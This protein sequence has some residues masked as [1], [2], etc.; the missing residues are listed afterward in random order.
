MLNADSL[1]A[2][3]CFSE[4][5]VFKT[6]DCSLAGSAKFIYRNYISCFVELT[7]RRNT[8]TRGHRKV[9]NQLV[10]VTLSDFI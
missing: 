7:F 2:V 8:S 3:C 4:L 10:T 9:A 5:I 6:V 1:L